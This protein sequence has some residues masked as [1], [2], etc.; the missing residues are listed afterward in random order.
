MA[1]HSKYSRVASILVLVILTVNVF[2]LSGL[3]FVPKAMASSGWLGDWSFRKSHVINLTSGA[4]TGYQV[5]IIVNYG[6][7][8]D[9]GQILYC[10]GKCRMD[11][12]DLR[13]TAA[14]GTSLLDYWMQEE[15]DG[16]YAVFWVKIS[17]DLSVSNAT[18]YLYY[19][20][21][22]ATTTS[23][24]ENT[25]IFFD[26]FLGSSIDLNK[27]ASRQGDV[28]VNGSE[29]ILTGTTPF[30][31]RGVIDSLTSFGSN[32]AVHT[33]ARTS[34][35]SIV[36]MH[37][38]GMR[39]NGSW[40][41][42]AGDTWTTGG[43]NVVALEAVTN[44]VSTVSYATL[45]NITVSHQYETAWKPGE[46]RFYQDGALKATV[47]SNVPDV[48]QVATF[49]EG[50]TPGTYCY[51]DWCFV[52]KWVDPEPYQG[53]WGTQEQIKKPDLT[54]YSTRNV[55]RRYGEPF[56]VEIKIS[57]PNQVQAFEF[58][59]QFNTT[60]LDYSNVT[61]NQ[62]QTGTVSVNEAQGIVNGSTSGTPTTG[63]H[64]LVTVIFVA[65][66]NHIW[67]DEGSIP[68]W[69]NNQTGTI[70]V[71]TAKLSYSGSPDL[72][73]Q[74][75]GLD[76]INVGSDLS[77]KWY[78]IKGDVNEDG[79]VDV[80]DLISVANY[81]NVKQGDPRWPQASRYDLTDPGAINILDMICVASNFWFKYNH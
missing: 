58:E 31:N 49:Q 9:S 56:I 38:C 6:S 20:K 70:S 32:S 12:R 80:L 37:F 77:F 53:A 71:Q 18:I 24:G 55:L 27:W 34:A 57:E 36:T 76:Q 74:K 39:E 48:S 26:D 21:S 17:A 4:G 64:T 43:A 33:R 7:G 13:F 81:F 28:S 62:W 66:I 65:A 2:A 10:N 68:G 54:L 51:V 42:R 25:F 63:N 1:N 79:A 46:S 78:P 61:W 14:D 15:V 44:N 52:T 60:M 47:T 3:S 16:N 40:D 8:N 41:N 59:L 23:N 19:G 45:S 11:F 30:S 69:I 35:E 22:D 73:Y 75:G 67:K 5:Q 50:Q 72:K 29:L